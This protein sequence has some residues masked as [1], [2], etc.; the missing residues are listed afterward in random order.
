VIHASSTKPFGF[1]PFYPG[2]GLGGHCIPIDPF[3]LFWKARAHDYDWIA[4]YAKLVVD[5]RNAVKNKK[6][7]AGKIVGA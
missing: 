5:S 1:S 6:R 2:H 3:Q 4:R 7:F